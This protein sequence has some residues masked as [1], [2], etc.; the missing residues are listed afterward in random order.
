MNL[1]DRS[2]HIHVLKEMQK[3]FDLVWNKVAAA[4]MMLLEA[5]NILGE[6]ESDLRH[7]IAI[8]EEDQKVIIQARKDHID[9]PA[10]VRC[11]DSYE[12]YLR[13]VGKNE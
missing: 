8:A 2:T 1:M 4:E 13:E 6:A 5:S 9:L 7:W 12:D 10:W 11:K 3:E